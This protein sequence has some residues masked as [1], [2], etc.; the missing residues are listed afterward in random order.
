[1]ETPR[2]GA[3]PAGAAGRGRPRAVSRL[4]L[5]EAAFELF[6][7]NG[8]SGTT[9]DQIANIA[10]VSRATFFNYFDAKSDVFWVD[11]DDSLE[12][13]QKS[14]QDAPSPAVMADVRRALLAVGRGFGSAQVPW[15]IT[16]R[17]LI[18]GAQELEASAVLR[19]SRIVRMLADEITRRTPG[20]PG[21]LLALA[22]ASAAVG[23]AVAAALTWTE[24]GTTR[25]ELTPY[26]EAALDPVC[27]GYQAAIDAL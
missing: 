16:H 18:G 19:L 7:E 23:A 11:L 27:A 26:L 20:A 3:A 8:Y 10:G 17:D 13:L 9:V 1:M 22:A 5:Q 21:A 24:A 15:A 25:G 12:V 2:S 6:L 4:M 14:L